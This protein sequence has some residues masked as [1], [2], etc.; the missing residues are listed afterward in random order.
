MLKQTLTT[1]EAAHTLLADE[2]A[3]WTYDGAMAITQY[4][5]DLSDDMGEDVEFCHVVIRCDFSELSANELVC[6]YGHLIGRDLPS[7]KSW[8]SNCEE[9]MSEIIEA[10][11]EYI[12]AELDN[13]N[14]IVRNC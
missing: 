4:I 1:N 9:I 7:D 8:A 14:F 11:A 10:A 3:N 6:Y 2:F 13:G 5:E 12:V